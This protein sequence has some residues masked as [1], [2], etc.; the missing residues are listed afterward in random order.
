MSLQERTKRERELERAAAVVAQCRKCGIGATRRNSVYG[1]GDPCAALMVVGEGP[2]E[3]EDKLGRPFVGRA[4]ELL[5]KM[6]ASIDLPREDVYI[7]NTVKCRP[8]LD[9]GHRIANRAPTP[10]EM[11]N[12]RPYLDQQIEVIRPRVILALGAPAAKSFM[13]EKF[14]ITK[15]RGQWFE[16]PSGIPVI[17]T[18]HPAYILRQTGGAMTEVK[19]LVWSDLKKV[20]ARLAETPAPAAEKPRQDGLFD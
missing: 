6:L 3:T 12:C 2:G 9:T 16:G 8:T 14:S 20:R 5:D 7:C 19:K 18:F 11:R 10:D 4:G 15:Q 13:G 1:E 17:A